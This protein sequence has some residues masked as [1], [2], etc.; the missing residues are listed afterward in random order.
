MESRKT[1]PIKALA[2]AALAACACA[3]A[4]VLPQAAWAM[5]AGDAA[6]LQNAL[7]SGGEV[8]LTK[9]IEAAGADQFVVPKGV[10]VEL[11][12]GGYALSSAVGHTIV[13]NGT[14]VVTGTGVVSNSTG[15]KG[16]LYNAPG[17]TA[18]LSGGTFTGT[19]WY[20]IK[21]L[22]AMTIN[23]GATVDQQHAGSSAIDNGY[24]GDRVNDC[25]VPYPASAIVQLTI[26]GGTFKNGMNIVK[27]DDFGVLDIVGGSFSNSVGAAILNWN[28]ATISG[29]EFS[30]TSVDHGVVANGY[31]SKNADAGELTI[32]GGTFV[33]AGNGTGSLF[34]F[35]DGA[36]TGGSIKI[37]GGTFT[38][39]CALG[40]NAPFGMTV[41]SGTFTDANVSKYVAAGNAIWADSAGVYTVLDEDS[42]AR[43]A[44][45]VVEIN[46]VKVYAGTVE[47]VQQAAAN[48]G[49]GAGEVTRVAYA[50]VYKF[51]GAVPSG[52]TAPTASS[53]L[54]GDRM[55]VAAVSAA[56]YSLE[57]TV[58]GADGTLVAIRDGS[59][60]MPAQDVVVTGTWTKVAADGDANEQAGFAKEKVKNTV[61]AASLPNTGD[62]AGPA[63][64]LVAAIA[65]C[66]AGGVVA[67]R[68]HTEDGRM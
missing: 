37:S 68:R 16:A 27:N 59:F 50:V 19:S 20:V 18:T 58:A 64:A 65:L 25:D 24:Y 14:L 29:G 62:P 55:Q 41:G 22:G 35:G 61:G 5:E 13:N 30:T 54:A 67:A 6:A 12:L 38:G 28:V 60:E 57:W 7:A 9:N 26:N 11:D 52:V 46:G 1:R 31:L 10:S 51:A 49:A 32:E 4:A 34:G 15:G 42:A 53:C 47:A 17:A 44:V 36:G 2:A 8:T 23:S 21:N 48:V 39:S 40:D 43:N 56:G 63:L 3:L 33:A 66:A 45:A